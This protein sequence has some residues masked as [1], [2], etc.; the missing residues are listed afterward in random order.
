MTEILQN[1][2]Q[3]EELFTP[4]TNPL[5]DPENIFKIEDDEIKVTKY[6][7]KAERAELEEQQRILAEREA[8][9]KGDNVG[10]RGL[11]HMMGGTELNL[12]KDKNVINQDLQ[13][14][15]WMMKDEKEMSD[16]EKMKLK[17]FQQK[18]KE[19]EDKQKKAWEQDLKKIKAEIIEIK[20]K[21]EERLLMLYK[22]KLFIDV[23][24]LEQELYI[25]RLVIMLHDGKE[26]KSDELKYRK[27]MEKLQIQK[28]EKEDLI[29]SFKGFANDLETNYADDTN[30]REQEKELRRMF[31][32]ANSRQ[33]QGF[34]KNGK[35][36]K[37][38]AAGEMNAR[39]QQLSQGIIDLDPFSG[40][41]KER[42]RKQIREE[43]D[44]EIFDFDK[45]NV[46]GLNEDEFERL[47]QERYTRVDMN[48]DKEK[49][50]NQIKQL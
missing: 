38:L 12:K 34:V 25:I 26:T 48:K 20:L 40:I 41:D 42:I 50:D 46:G 10:Q 49:L 36:K 32:E 17:E 30:I 37:T 35:G 2:N 21:F 8:L 4:S 39:E 44:R 5:E 23:R 18:K 3:E 24:V 33:I 15:D 9:L 7:T 14:E 1:L 11:K 47:V 13:M 19:F 28:Q 31:P 45:D 27:E 16:E 6:L 22:K 43:D 29:T